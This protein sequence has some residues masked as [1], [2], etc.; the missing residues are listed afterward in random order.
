MRT[1]GP[2]TRAAALWL[3]IFVVVSLIESPA[4]AVYLA[5]YGLV[6]YALIAAAVISAT[7]DTTRQR[8]RECPACGLSVR[9][10][11]TLC[12]HCGF[13]FAAAAKRGLAGSQP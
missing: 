4:H 12:G 5:I 7:S 13:D 6:P 1:W 11:K 8:L 10:G 2:I 3:G 9:R